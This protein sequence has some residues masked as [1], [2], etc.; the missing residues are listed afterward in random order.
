MRVVVKLHKTALVANR[1][2]YLSR[3][4]CVLCFW[5]WGWDLVVVGER[6]RCRLGDC[7]FFA[8]LNV[9]VYRYLS[10]QDLFCEPVTLVFDTMFIL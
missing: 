5:R 2:A 9:F 6:R 10:F 4:I 3:C 7:P 8:F 1:V